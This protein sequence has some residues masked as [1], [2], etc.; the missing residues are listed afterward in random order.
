MVILET[1]FDVLSATIG[2]VLGAVFAFYLNRKRNRK[3][4]SQ[5]AISRQE[6]QQS[7]EENARLLSQIKEKEN[8]ILQMQVQI[9][10]DKANQNTRP[11]K[12]N[13]KTA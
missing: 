4:L 7:K 6:L 9:L 10:G 2:A 12:R 13:K 5:Q 1:L 11:K 8:L 3:M